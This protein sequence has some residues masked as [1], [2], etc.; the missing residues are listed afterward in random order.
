MGANVLHN[1][2]MGTLRQDFAYAFRMLARRPGFTFAAAL[3]LALGIAANTTIFSLISAVL[4]RPLPYPNADRLVTLWTS[5]PES[6]GRLDIFSPPNYLDVAARNRS[7][8]AVGGYD[9]ASFTLAGDGEPEY[10]P[11]LNM[12]ASMSRVLGMEP[13]V[14]RWFTADEDEGNQTVVVLSD[15]LWRTR[16]GADSGVLGRAI[17]LNGRS[18][19]V[20]GVLPPRAGFP[21]PLTQIYAPISFSANDKSSQNRANVFLNVIARMRG[22]VS[23]ATAEAEVRT[24]A[25]ALASEYPQATGIQ[26][27]AIPL[28]E[29]MVGNVRPML[30]VLWVA[31]AFM[32]AVG[33]ANVANLLLTH[34]AA[35]SREF[36]LRR[37]LGASNGRLVRQLLTESLTLSALGGVLGLTFAAW[38][39][40]AIAMHLPQSFPQLRDVTLSPQ[41]LWFT[42]AISLATGILFGIAPALGASRRDMAQSLR[43][44]ERGGRT[45]VS[46]R[47][48]RMLVVAEVAAVLV[49]LVGAGLVLR[50]LMRLSHVDPGFRTRN[51]IAWQIFLPNSR[52]PNPAVRRSFYRSIIEQTESLPG[53]Q[54]V[55][56]AQ[57]LPFGPIDLV[58]DADFEIAGRPPVSADQ[59]P[60]ALI[61]RA[62]AGYFAAMEIPVRRGRVFSAQDGETS[63]VAVISEALARRYF[64]GEDPIGAH[65]LLGSQKLE[66]QIVGVVGDVKHINL[67]TDARPEFY[68]P[69]TRFTSG[70][71]GLVVRSAGPAAPL[72]PALRQRVW[73]VDNAL[74]G[75]LAVPVE[76]LLYASLAPARL[77]TVLLGFFA[78]ATLALGLI[79]VYGVLS[80]SVRQ[81]TREIGIRLALGATGNDVL[82]MVLGEALG[83]TGAG[84]GA[85]LIAAFFL[86]SY[87]KSLLYGISGFDPL[88]YGIVAFAVTCAAL[89]A[90]YSPARRATRIDPAASLRAD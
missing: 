17:M 44:G 6:P 79:G 1:W 40:P 80:Y 3:T 57:P 45:N 19:K 51:L 73:S 62:S 50:S 29:S 76:G 18:Y 56:L 71:A 63:S 9:Q 4:L 72:I 5:Y 42:L 48:G 16:F 86:S 77:A 37:S 32:L 15:A 27:G 55:G 70:G 81:G 30:L 83:L 14:G 26:M 59:R 75:N 34:A 52:Y 74:A 66:M 82:K 12:T 2:T 84:V 46:R 88:T 33:C 22:G 89:L 53:V 58:A 10:V 21:S 65:L 23:T 13:R 47:L 64:P 31:V 41:V 61:T 7:F 8:E 24:I 35:R 28:Q 39:V 11:G 85:G 87:M 69:M 25:A 54:A 38:A 67:Q 36:A 90:A 68:L 49:L 43:D 60:L 20:I 78:G